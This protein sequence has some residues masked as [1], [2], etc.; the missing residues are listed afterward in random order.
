MNNNWYSAIG[1]STRDIRIYEALQ[2]TGGRASLRS[3]ADTTGMNRGTVHETIKQLLAKGVVSFTTTGK[4]K[5]YQAAPVSV[6]LGLIREH[7]EDLVTA[8]KRAL[9]MMAHAARLHRDAPY[10]QFAAVYE[11]FEGLAAI[12]R[13]VLTSMERSGDSFYR[14]ISSAGISEFLYKNFPNYSRQRIRRK[15]FVRVLAA[16]SSSD[17]PVV[18]AERKL[19]PGRKRPRSY[20]IIYAQKVAAISLGEHNQPFGIVIDNP[21]LAEVEKLAFDQLWDRL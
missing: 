12:L 8:E 17:E 15:L 5:R 16:G 6:F 4:Q 21:D 9:E 14:V 3:I 13:D 11:D 1:L 19:L 7:R 10:R 20:K 2:Q 18:M